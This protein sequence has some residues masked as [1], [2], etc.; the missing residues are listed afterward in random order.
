[1]TTKMKG[2]EIETTGKITNVNLRKQIHGDEYVKAFDVSISCSVPKAVLASLVPTAKSDRSLA[3]ILFSKDDLPKLQ[4]LYPLKLAHKIE[5]VKVKIK[6]MEFASCDLATIELTPS[7]GGMIDLS[8]KVQGTGPGRN[9]VADSLWT[10]I[11]EETK[12]KIV[13]LQGEL[14][15][16]E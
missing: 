5:G 8:F 9:T 4:E 11:N 1:M 3:D 10:L 13:Q 15:G 6:Q 2:L 16:I 12:I 7:A 14:P